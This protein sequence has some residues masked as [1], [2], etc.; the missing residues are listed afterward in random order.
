MIDPVTDWFECVPLID[1]P[2][3]QKACCCCCCCY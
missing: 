1:S 2:T 3:A